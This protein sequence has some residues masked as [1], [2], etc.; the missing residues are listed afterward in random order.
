MRTR[1]GRALT[2]DD[3]SAIFTP[4]YLQA[5]RMHNATKGFRITGI[6]PIDVNVFPEERF[7]PCEVTSNTAAHKYIDDKD[8]PDDTKTSQSHYE[9]EETGTGVT[10]DSHKDT[11]GNT[12]LSSLISIEYSHELVEKNK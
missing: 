4:V 5:E 9:N 2:R 10:D 12:D 1:L 8:D 7:A 6:Y 11:G 3:F